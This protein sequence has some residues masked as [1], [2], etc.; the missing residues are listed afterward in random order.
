MAEVA[1][2][3]A[4]DLLRVIARLKS[5]AGGQHH[6]FL[7]LQTAVAVIKVQ[8]VAAEFEARATNKRSDAD[9]FQPVRCAAPLRTRIHHGGAAHGARNADGPGQT[10]QPSA[11]GTAGQ[12]WDRFPCQ[13]FHHA[14]LGVQARS[15]Q[16]SQA[17]GQARQAVVMN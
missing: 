2:G 10:I 1:A 12:G 9:R 8:L 13:G 15:L 17:E 5:E 16:F 6:Q 3:D 14:V 11:C 4:G 7:V